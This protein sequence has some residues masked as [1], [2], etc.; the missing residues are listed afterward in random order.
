MEYG[1]ITQYLIMHGLIWEDKKTGELIGKAHD[2]TEV[3]FGL[4][5][6][7]VHAQITENYFQDHPTPD[8]W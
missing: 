1:I 2:D 3:N 4:H 7:G 5:F 6:M 8:T